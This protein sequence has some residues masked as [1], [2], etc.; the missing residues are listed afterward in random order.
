MRQAHPQPTTHHNHSRQA[1]RAAALTALLALGASSRSQ[2][3]DLGYRG[4]DLRAGVNQSSDW[5]RGETLGASMDL[6]E[7]RGCNLITA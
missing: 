7:L 5:D 2:A 4:F 3:V 1:L 6:G